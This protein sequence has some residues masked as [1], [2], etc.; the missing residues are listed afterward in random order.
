MVYYDIQLRNV[1]F[2]K[3]FLMIWGNAHDTIV[4][5]KLYV[6]TLRCKQYK[7]HM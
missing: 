4:L 2:M 7:K 1:M 6:Y 3:D 5:M